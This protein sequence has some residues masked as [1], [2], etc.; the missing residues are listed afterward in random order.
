[1]PYIPED[2]REALARGM[3]E[4]A[5]TVGELTYVLYS[6]CKRFY[7]TKP[8][9]YITIALIL[10]ALACT[11]MEFYRRVGAPYEDEKREEHGDV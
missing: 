10:G 6:A 4:D 11:A 1:M 3:M 8:R 5:E 9:R 2:R 7:N